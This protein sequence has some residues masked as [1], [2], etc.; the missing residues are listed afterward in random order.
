MQ[1]NSEEKHSPIGS[2]KD[3]LVKSQYLYDG[4]NGNNGNGDKNYSNK[5]NG[6][7]NRMSYENIE[8]LENGYQNHHQ[9]NFEVHYESPS[10][11]NLN[12]GEVNR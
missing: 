8:N 11:N 7:Q 12:G 9:K 5:A 1:F 10:M 6:S 4:N 2:L 3:S